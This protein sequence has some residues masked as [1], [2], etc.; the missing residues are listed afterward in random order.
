MVYQPTPVLGGKACTMPLSPRTPEAMSDANVGMAPC[1]AYL[2]IKSGRIPSDEKN[3]T[4]LLR[5]ELLV[6]AAALGA[7]AAP[8][9]SINEPINMT[10][11]ARHA[12][13]RGFDLREPKKVP[14]I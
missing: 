5:A 3:T 1:A 14:N 13:P 11:K 12:R 4:L 6:P 10:L 9:G 7:A 2:S 8:T